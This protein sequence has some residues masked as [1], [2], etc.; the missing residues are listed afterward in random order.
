MRPYAPILEP[1][2]CNRVRVQ[3][4]PIWGRTS[5]R[6]SASS[7]SAR[8]VPSRERSASLLHLKN[9]PSSKRPPLLL[10]PKN[11]PL[12]KPFAPAL[13][14][15]DLPS[16]KRP[17]SALQPEDMPTK[18]RSLKATPNIIIK[19]DEII[20]LGGEDFDDGFDS[21]VQLSTFRPYVNGDIGRP[22]P[23]HFGAESPLIL[24]GSIALPIQ[25]FPA[26]QPT[27]HG[28]PFPVVTPTMI[29][30]LPSKPCKVLDDFSATE[31]TLAVVDGRRNEL[32]TTP[33]MTR[34]SL[35]RL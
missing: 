8:D 16:Y 30:C 20:D 14:P 1:E 19:S 18:K 21:L 13:L 7:R 17:A 5:K 23:M 29:H 25:Q 31:M 3:R 35:D 33:N 2:D 12:Y 10:H 4:W 11:L 27:T 22:T 34:L 9:L 32:R 15:K 28:S 24:R 6:T 26:I